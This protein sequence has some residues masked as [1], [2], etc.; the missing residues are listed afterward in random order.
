MAIC[1]DLYVFMSIGCLLTVFCAVAPLTPS[2]GVTGRQMTR[3][4]RGFDS[5]SGSRLNFIFTVWSISEPLAELSLILRCI[6]VDKI[7]LDL[8]VL[9]YSGIWLQIEHGAQR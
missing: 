7:L 3:E 9:K 6:L 8:F 4:S 5:R 1:L 2:R